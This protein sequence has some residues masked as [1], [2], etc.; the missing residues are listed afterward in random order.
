[1]QDVF[2]HQHFKLPTGHGVGCGC[3]ILQGLRRTASNEAETL[4]VQESYLRTRVTNAGSEQE[5]QRDCT[6]TKH[7]K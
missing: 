4:H 2:F 3:D 1:M 7:A 5:F 6:K